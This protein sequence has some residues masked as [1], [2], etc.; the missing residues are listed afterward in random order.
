MLFLFFITHR[1][2]LELAQL[3]CGNYCESTFCE[4]YSLAENSFGRDRKLV[5]PQ[6][7]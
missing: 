3:F 6:K 1:S 5:K 4:I 2:D 7:F